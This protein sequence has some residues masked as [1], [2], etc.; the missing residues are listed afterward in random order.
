VSVVSAIE[1]IMDGAFCGGGRLCAPENG[2]VCSAPFHNSDRLV[3]QKI[4]IDL[5]QIKTSI[6]GRKIETIP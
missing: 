3:S 6:I 1:A 5:E 4:K 2:R